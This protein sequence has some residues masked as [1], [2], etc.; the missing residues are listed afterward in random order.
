MWPRTYT[1]TRFTHVCPYRRCERSTFGHYR[2]IFCSSKT[3]ETTK[4][5]HILET[6]SPSVTWRRNVPNAIPAAGRRPSPGPLGSGALVTSR[7][8]DNRLWT[9]GGVGW[10]GAA[11]L[12]FDC[13]NRS[14]NE[15]AEGESGERRLGDE[16][17]YGAFRDPHESGARRRWSKAGKAEV[18]TRS[19][20]RRCSLLDL[21][22]GRGHRGCPSS[23]L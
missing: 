19:C 5:G 22:R 21:L 4:L 2:W 7:H 11:A 12:C 16:R 3:D 6:V 10:G 17:V 23:R 9:R 20:G 15:A 14:K 1:E 18:L 8:H 13:R